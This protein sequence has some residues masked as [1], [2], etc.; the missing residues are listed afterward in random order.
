MANSV[1]SCGLRAD[2]HAMICWPD[3]DCSMI[4]ADLHLTGT[5]PQIAIKK[6]AQ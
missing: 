6:S 5:Q 3:F 1:E 4:R 2:L